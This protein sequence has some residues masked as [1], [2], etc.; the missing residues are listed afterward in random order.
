VGL[1][2]TLVEAKYAIGTL[3]CATVQMPN[4]A[5]IE[6][7]RIT[8][9]EEKIKKKSQTSNPLPNVKNSKKSAV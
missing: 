9:W 7:K 3:E 5:L 1:N 2:G 6:T 4:L 8:V